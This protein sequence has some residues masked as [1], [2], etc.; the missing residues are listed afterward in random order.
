MENRLTFSGD[1]LDDRNSGFGDDRHNV[2]DV[3]HAHRSGQ[4]RQQPALARFRESTVGHHQVDIA[5][6]VSRQHYRQWRSLAACAVPK[7]VAL[8]LKEDTA[9][10]AMTQMARPPHLAMLDGPPS[11]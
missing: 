6:T 3:C 8:T 5:A 9:V 4:F 7:L 1:K 2:G 11:L 10:S